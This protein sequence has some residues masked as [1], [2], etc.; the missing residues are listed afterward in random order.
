MKRVLLLDGDIVA[1]NAA[2]VAEAE[3]DFGDGFTVLWSD[4]QTALRIARE[5]IESLMARLKADEV[6]FCLTDT[7]NWR[8]DVL[9]SYKDNR[10]SVRKPIAL[11]RLK[12]ELS[13]LYRTELWPTLE[14]DDVMGILAT[15]E[16]FMPDY[17]KIIVSEDKDLRTIPATVFNPAKDT[18]PVRVSRADADLWLY[19]QAI[20]G[21]ATDG[22]SGCKGIGV[23][24]ALQHLE[25]MYGYERYTHT[26]KSG[27]RKGLSEER[28]RKVPMPDY[29]SIA[30]SL[31][32]RAGLSE[33]Y[34]ITQAQVARI[35]RDEDYDQ[36]NQQ[37]KPWRPD[38]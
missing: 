17:E 22:Y 23:K 16:S 37:V 11:A 28:W 34:A 35:C 24:T 13:D 29:W 33:D 36:T 5:K 31:Y 30:K 6:V 20:G 12:A 14:A 21:D 9:P 7:T 4:W 32:E 15:R 1:F 26:F 8:K 2:V 25:G 10:K 18:K 3:D 27:E 38:L 19:A